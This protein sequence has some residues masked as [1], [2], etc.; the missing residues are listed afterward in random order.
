MVEQSRKPISER[1]TPEGYSSTSTQKA[2]RSSDIIIYATGLERPSH[3]A[4]LT[5]IDFR[6]R[7]RAAAEGTKWGS[8]GPQDLFFGLMV[9]R[10]SQNMMM[11]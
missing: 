9:G 10:L 5:K 8:A 7:E 6:R 11:G 2:S 3:R 1:I 4:V